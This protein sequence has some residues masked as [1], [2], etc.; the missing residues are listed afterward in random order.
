MKKR[1]FKIV[2]SFFIVGIVILT[3]GL[4]ANQSSDIVSLG[5]GQL[6]NTFSSLQ[7]PQLG[8]LANEEEAKGYQPISGIDFNA[9][10]TG[11]GADSNFI[12]L[13]RTIFNWGIAI[14]VILATLAVIVGAVQYMTT[15]AIYDKKEGRQRMTSAIG[16]LILALM[17]WLILFTINENIF[18]SNFLLKLQNLKE[19][20]TKNQ[21][22]GGVV[23]GGSNLA[24]EQQVELNKKEAED[25]LSTAEMYKK[26]S[27]RWQRIQRECFD[28]DEKFIENSTN[29]DCNLI[30]KING[31]SGANQ[32][33]IQAKEAEIEAREK[34]VELLKKN[35]EIMGDNNSQ[36]L[37]D[38]ESNKNRLDEINNT[39][40][41]SSGS[42]E[43]QNTQNN[44][45]SFN[46]ESE[47]NYDFLYDQQN[48][49]GV[50][51][52]RLTL[53][54]IIDLNK[55]LK[56]QQESNQNS[57]NKQVEYEL[58]EQQK[59]NLAFQEQSMKNIIIKNE[60]IDL[61]KVSNE[62]KDVLEIFRDSCCGRK[63]V[64]AGT[65]TY[66][67][68]FNVSD[69]YPEENSFLIERSVTNELGADLWT[70]LN[71]F[72]SRNTYPDQNMV[73]ITE[74]I[75]CRDSNNKSY[76]RIPENFREIAGEYTSTNNKGVLAIDLLRNKRY[77]S[78]FN[79]YDATVVYNNNSWEI[80]ID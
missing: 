25:L 27:D 59:N 70:S 63:V 46:P 44:E 73:E 20:N 6:A 80:K 74:Y 32:S 24:P 57:N 41:S 33:A 38:I 71:F 78:E 75:K 29:P 68:S 47:F 61:T 42:F 34:A 12:A 3:I 72:V 36:S 40:N 21:S 49:T 37:E 66:T 4:F 2:I 48:N 14:A 58:T 26:E 39:G 8:D 15:D 77:I 19:E 43:N 5:D 45:T 53:Q 65:E 1:N 50:D 54:E 23:A 51:D 56:D 10:K 18:A 17:S 35:A 7:Q 22:S 55:N 30:A 13:L 11:A 60:S 64:I 28:A 9:G 79:G 16:G 76:C 69:V 67:H 31:F 52:G 62:L